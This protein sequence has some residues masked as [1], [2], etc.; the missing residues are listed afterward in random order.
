VPNVDPARGDL[1][2]GVLG[3]GAIGCYVGCKL[4]AGGSSVLLVGRRPLAEA[5]GG[6]FVVGELDGSSA[7]I[8]ASRVACSTDAGGLGDCDVILCC[9]KSAQTAAAGAQLAGVLPAGSGGAVTV[10]LQNGV[11]NADVLRSALEGRPALAGIVGFNVVTPSAG[12]FRRTTSGPLVI[13]ASADP[14]VQALAASL[15]AAGLELK[16]AEDI[17]SLQWGKL[18]MNLNNAI[19]ALS[20][21]PTRELLFTPGY[22]RILAGIIA[23]SL[24]VIGRAGVRPAS[25]TGMPLGLLPHVLRLPTPLLR[26]VAR[27]QLKIDPEA[28]SSMWEDLKRGRPTEVDDLNGEIV[29]LA[30]SVGR[31]APENRRLVD[32]VHRVEKEGRGSPGLSPEALSRALASDAPT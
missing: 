9:V 11:H 2:V 21:V 25:L 24:D 29:R 17:R 28:R 7:R 18:I 15:R 14:R 10:S 13:E 32:L 16:L 30:R 12:V 1:R 5:D 26:L 31:D 20:D 19:S 23:E 3:A 8:P 6:G 4:A 22:R 27:T